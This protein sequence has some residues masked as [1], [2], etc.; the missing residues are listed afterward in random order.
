MLCIALCD[1]GRNK[2]GPQ[3]TFGRT[4]FFSPQRS[5][6]VFPPPSWRRMAPRKSRVSTRDS[7]SK[8]MASSEVRFLAAA[9][10]WCL[11]ADD[12]VQYVTHD[13]FRRVLRF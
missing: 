4:G 11:T 10:S 7:A 9:T 3:Y 8:R 6:Q 13:G 5:P 1:V 2:V 12:F